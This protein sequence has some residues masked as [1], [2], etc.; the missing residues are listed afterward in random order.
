MTG[1]SRCTPLGW[2][3]ST[4]TAPPKRPCGPRITA[5]PA[6]GRSASAA[7]S[8]A[9][10]ST[11]ST[12]NLCLLPG[13]QEAVALPDAQGAGLIGFIASAENAGPVTLRRALAE[14]L[15]PVMVPGELRVLPELPRNPNGKVDRARLRTLAAEP[16]ATGRWSHPSSE[17][18]F[19]PR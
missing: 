10:G 11:Y 6:P 8:Q 9:L 2:I 13:V 1:T 4:N 18:R 16:P 19:S 17:I 5:S 7:P 15:P 3:W 14:K 12:A